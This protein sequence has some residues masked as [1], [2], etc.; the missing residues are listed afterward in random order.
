M[1]NLVVPRA[2]N[3]LAEGASSFMSAFGDAIA[4]RRKSADEERQKKAYY[5]FLLDL[6]KRKGQT[7]ENVART[8]ASGKGGAGTDQRKDIE[9]LRKQVND[10]Q[11]RVDNY[12]KT[13]LHGIMADTLTPEERGI[14]ENEFRKEY[15]MAHGEDRA[16]LMKRKQLMGAVQSLPTFK[17]EKTVEEQPETG[18]SLDIVAPKPNLL[19]GP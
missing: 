13:R 16:I 4:G 2:S 10:A 18:V 6:N 19:Q 15:L 17:N 3:P 5:D 12:A 14:K 11:E 8:K 9:A 1:R 7:Q